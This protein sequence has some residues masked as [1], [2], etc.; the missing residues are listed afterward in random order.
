MN[1]IETFDQ[2]LATNT[3]EIAIWAFLLNLVL[4]GIL[5]YLLS[6]IY[7]RYGQ[8]LSNRGSFSKNFVM[9]AMTTMLII[10]IVKSSLALSLGLVGAL[11]IVRFRAAI[12]EPEELAYLF[13]NIAIG[14]GL[15]ANQRFVTVTGFFV[16]V[17][18]IYIMHHRKKADESASLQLSVR[19]GKGKEISLDKVIDVL[20]QHTDG[21]NLRR[22]SDSNGQFEGVFEISLDHYLSIDELKN[23]L[24]QV[25]EEVSVVLIDKSY[26]GI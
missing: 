2:F 19:S 13:L 8:T 1:K 9:I 26:L 11:S 25:D 15:G 23:A 24:Q 14:L 22:Y 12:K 20:K 18:V 21:L 17:G 5:A 16:L 6:L 4:T 3:P 10:T 7:V